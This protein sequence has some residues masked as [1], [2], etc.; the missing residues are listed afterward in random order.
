MVRKG[1]KNVTKEKNSL[2]PYHIQEYSTKYSSIF[3]VP[4]V[5]DGLITRVQWFGCMYNF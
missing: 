4:L 2:T 5:Y 1:N 3:K